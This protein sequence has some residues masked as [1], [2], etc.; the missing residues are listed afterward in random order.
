MSNLRKTPIQLLMEALEKDDKTRAFFSACENKFVFYGFDEFL[1]LERKELELSFEEGFNNT[2][3]EYDNE[4]DCGNP[5]GRL[6]LQ[7]YE[8]YNSTFGDNVE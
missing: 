1:K 6:E 4:D 3:Y 2:T 7:P 5:Y 8:Y